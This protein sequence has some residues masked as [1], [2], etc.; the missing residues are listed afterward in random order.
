[1]DGSGVTQPI[2]V[3]DGADVTQGAKAD[4]KNT[5]TDTTA[6]SAIALLKEISFME[7]TPATRAVTNAG[8]FAV[9]L[10]GASNNINNV[11]GTVSLPTGAATAANQTNAAQKTQIVDGSGNVIA[12]TANNL[13]VQ[14][15][16]CSGSGVSAVDEA[17]MTEGTSVFAPAGGY[18]K[19]AITNLTTGQE[20]MVAL[21]PSRSFHVS[22]YDASGNALL[23]QQTAANSMP[24]ILP[25]ATITALTPPTTVTV[26]QATGTNLHTVCDSGCGGGSGGTSATDESAFTQGTTTLTPIGG[27]FKTS[28]TA[29]TSGQAGVAQLTSNGGLYTNVDKIQGTNVSVNAGASDTGT[30]RVALS[31]DGAL[32]LQAS[33]TSGTSN[34]T[35]T[36]TT[37]TGL[38]PYTKASILVNITGAGAA[39]GTLQLFLEDSVDGGTTW[40]D[41][42]SSNTFTFGASTTTQQFWIAGEIASSGSQGASAVT[43]TLTAGVARQGPFGD[44]IRVREKVSGVSGSPTGVTYT[45]AGVFKR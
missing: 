17:A 37:T 20:G 27:L 22:L 30:Q 41:L 36:R 7:Q 6:V 5:A 23:G 33:Q 32:T 1:V 31:Y 34:A 15:A 4:A 43:E 13:N 24:V 12:S 35:T 44:R 25:A 45:I 9:Q 2:S 38:G 14:C 28:Y 21:T 19:S 18:Y 10:T 16:N 8:T 29:L 26:T 42:V 11:S 40:N 39:T 3:A